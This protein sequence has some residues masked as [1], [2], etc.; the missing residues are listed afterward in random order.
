MTIRLYNTM[1]RKLEEFKPLLPNHVGFY[2]C[3]PTVYWDQHI[4]NMR[5]FVNSDIL[6]R[7]F[8]ENGYDVKHVMNITDVGHLTSDEDSGEDKMEKGAARENKSAWDIAKMYT[9]SF[10]RDI[11]SLN[12]IKPTFMPHATDYI[13]EQIEQIK[14]LEELGYTYE[15]PGDGI[16]YDTSK[17]ADYG[18][19]GG[20]NLSELRGGLR[21]DDNGKKNPTDFAL[22][23]FSPTDKK[24][25]MEWES[26]WGV[27]FPGWHIECS[28]MSMKLLG[29]HFDI[30]VGGQEHIKV[31][32]SDEIAQS[33]PIVGKPWVN[34]WVH[35]EWLLSKD[36][37][38]SK[39]SGDFLTVQ[40]LIE[41]GYD[42]MA[43]RYLLLLGHY[44]QPLDFSFEALDA[45]TNGYKSIIRKVADLITS[46][47]SEHVND[48][49]Y[50]EWHNKILDTV[51]DN[52]KTAEALV[53]IQ[54]L[55]K[56]NKVN[57]ATKLKLFEFIDRLLGLQ[58]VNRA[59]KLLDIESVEAPEEIKKLAEERVKA[60]AE[61]NWE[62]ADK[63]RLE[64]DSAGWN[65][66]DT[67][68]GPKIIKKM[69]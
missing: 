51:S 20:Q 13:P 53:Y 23:K 34:Y 11:T 54:E 36:G 8:I 57:A 7:M 21:V 37:K 25:A 4:G 22:W 61:K 67:K 1:S 27:G 3:G 66:V 47:G 63:I 6:K 41:R 48:A 55:L 10:I 40:D 58:F 60:K 49:V 15:I 19:L 45:A 64:I 52:L 9:D 46:K 14:K 31:H 26:P 29:P 50:D 17:F 16:Y 44:H 39:S 5:S 33:E 59:Q 38:M 68:D 42:S 62:L 28:A 30:H 69:A 18:A 32:H 35:Y 12:I 65:V 56:D 2:S 43:F 24:R